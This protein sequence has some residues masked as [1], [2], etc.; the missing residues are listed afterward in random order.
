MLSEAEG[1]WLDYAWS[2][3]ATPERHRT[4]CTANGGAI[5][6]PGR[7]EGNDLRWPGYLGEHYRPGRSVLCVG[8]VHREGTAAL[9]AGDRV[10]AETD[11]ALVEGAR[12]WLGTGRS[13]HSDERYLERLRAAYVRALPSW[14]VAMEAPLSSAR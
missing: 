7:V 3:V 4:A 2:V 13:A 1:R 14:S 5:P 12:E 6:G 11:R 8:A 9:Q 10:I